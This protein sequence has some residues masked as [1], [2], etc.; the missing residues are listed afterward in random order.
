[1]GKDLWTDKTVELSDNEPPELASHD[2]LLV[3]IANP[4]SIARMAPTP[5]TLPAATR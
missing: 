1:M 2:V 3:R 5:G 4:K